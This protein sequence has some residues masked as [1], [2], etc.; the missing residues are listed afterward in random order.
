MQKIEEVILFQ[1]EQ[2]S[3]LSKQYSQREFDEK[4]LGITVDQWVIMKIVQESTDLTQRELAKK[5]RR[6]PASIT[7]TI[8]L[9]EKKNLLTRVDVP[10]SRRTYHIELTQTGQD[11]IAK[12]LPMVKAQRKNSVK[13][14]SKEELEMMSKMLAKMR[15]NMS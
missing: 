1:I 4:K 15:E 5:S 12:H 6:D 2:T 9:L 13:G 10:D 14:L 7:R 11:F 3:K 8:D